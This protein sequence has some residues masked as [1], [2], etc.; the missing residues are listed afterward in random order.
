[1]SGRQPRAGVFNIFEGSQSI[2]HIPVFLTNGAGS[3]RLCRV[4][5]GL[6]G[7]Q[8]SG[9]RS[10][11]PDLEK[12]DCKREGRALCS[13][14]GCL[15]WERASPVTQAFLS[16]LAYHRCLRCWLE[17]CKGCTSVLRP[18]CQGLLGHQSSPCLA[19]GMA[20]PV[21]IAIHWFLLGCL[22][23]LQAAPIHVPGLPLCRVIGA[24]VIP[25]AGGHLAWGN[26]AVAGESEDQSPTTQVW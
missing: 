20:L 22:P 9:H 17:P 21:A 8:T 1:M 5:L 4:L 14:R 19:M 10:S 24:G 11:S 12:W 6:L 23:F 3:I 15:G 18:A 25:V 7:L 16:H 13:A 2:Q 26:T